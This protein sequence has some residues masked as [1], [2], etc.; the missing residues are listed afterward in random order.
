MNAG[1]DAQYDKQIDFTCEPLEIQYNTMRENCGELYAATPIDGIYDDASTRLE[2]VEMT[3][4][5][6]GSLT[7]DFSSIQEGLRMLNSAEHNILNEAAS[8]RYIGEKKSSVE[9]LKASLNDVND[10]YS[11]FGS[12]FNYKP[13][14]TATEHA[15]DDID[16]RIVDKAEVMGD[17]APVDGG[18]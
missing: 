2:K 12:A 14:I 17:N 3:R 15:E 9:E 18:L 10:K 5:A 6:D 7:V 13:A 16:V 4:Q 8:G 11:A 1:Q